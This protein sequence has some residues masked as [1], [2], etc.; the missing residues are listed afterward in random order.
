VKAASRRTDRKEG[1]LEMSKIYT[2]GIA[3][4]FAAVTIAAT[5]VPASAHHHG[6]HHRH[7]GDW[8]WGGGGI[9]LDFGSVVYDDPDPIYC[10]G[11]HGR[12]YIC[13][14]N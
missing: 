12:L 5:T 13:G 2:A 4:L 8:G 14:Y 7:H 10:V 11:R 6:H 9:V 1:N 3:A